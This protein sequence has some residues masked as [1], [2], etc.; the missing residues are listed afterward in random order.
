MFCVRMA[1]VAFQSMWNLLDRCLSQGI[2]AGG[3]VLIFHKLF[4]LF[5]VGSA[6]HRT[7]FQPVGV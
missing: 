7:T 5:S 4:I 6:G 3:D 1:H 2:A